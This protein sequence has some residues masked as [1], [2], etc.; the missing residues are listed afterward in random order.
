MTV[1]E[2]TLNVLKPLLA[3][4]GFKSDELEG[5]ADI[6]CK[7]LKEEST[8]EE[9]KNVCDGLVPVAALIQ[10]VGNRYV[11]ETTEKVEK[12]YQGFIKPDVNKD[13]KPDKPEH[14]D[15][16]PKALTA[17]DIAKMI[18]EESSKAVTAA[19]APIREKEEK[20]RLLS[21]LNSHE[22]IKAMP[23]VF[24]KNYSLDKEENLDSVVAQMETDYAALK[25]N[26]AK[27][28]GY[29]EAPKDADGK[30]ETDDLIAYMDKMAERKTQEEK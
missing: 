21:L 14:Q 17:E 8:D 13:D 28:E 9:I 5:L 19:L 30:G 10:K 15:E 2:K 3:A 1:K 26:I 7:N 11:T 6:A 12:K 23:E 25:Q 24:R 22:N 16:P 4:K 27:Q 18:A 29:I 20:S